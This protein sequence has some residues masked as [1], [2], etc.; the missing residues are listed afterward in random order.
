V[1]VLNWRDT[2]HPE[3]GG[4]EVYVEHVAAGLVERGAT[5]TLFCARPSGAAATEQRDG[6]RIL[7]RGGRFTVYLWAALYVL[8]GRVGRFDRVLEVQNGMPF[9]A[10]LY[11]RRPVTVLVHH[12]HR[13][14]WPV[15]LPA[16][17]ARLG[18]WLEA[19]VAPWVNRHNLYVTVSESTA[20]EL[21][22]LGV[23]PARIHV[24]HNGIEP[25]PAGTLRVRRS[26]TPMVVVLGRL[27]P[28]KRVEIALDA[29]AA[30]RDDVPEVELHVVGRGWWERRLREHADELG[31]GRAVTFHGYVDEHRKHVL[32]A[33]SWVLAMPSLKEGWGLVVVEAAE[34][35]TPAVA[36]RGAGGLSESIVHD[37]TGLLVDSPAEFTAA[38]RELVTCPGLRAALGAQAAEESARYRWPATVDGVA[39]VLGV[40][41]PG[42][43]QVIGLTT[44]DLSELGDEAQRLP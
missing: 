25:P 8:L 5:V 30:L 22:G 36:F 13:E 27:V 39:C 20:D 40:P 19:R 6:Y 17:Q 31:L 15:V 16:S 28:H 11:T 41:A 38:L 4:S 32:L 24:V 43:Q 29:L 18:W 10:S 42:A 14:Q 21:V 12:V 2:S 35:G 34:H 23:D 37:R 1:L 3:G 26:P 9:L 7:R 33:R 44:V